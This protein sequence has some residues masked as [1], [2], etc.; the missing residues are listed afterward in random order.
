[1]GASIV[2]GDYAYKPGGWGAAV[3][4]DSGKTMIFRE[5]LNFSGRSQLPK[6][7]KNVY[8][9]SEK[10]EFIL[11]SEIKCQKSAI[12]TDSISRAK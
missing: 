8:L 12:F 2:I 9:L 4:P 3:P 5:K 7:K 6:M 10:T 11:S 1:V